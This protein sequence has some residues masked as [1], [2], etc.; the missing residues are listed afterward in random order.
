MDKE[1]NREP[2]QALRRLI[3]RTRLAVKK[4]WAEKGRDIPLG[5]QWEDPDVLPKAKAKAKARAKK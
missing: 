3:L 2:D 5:V 4:Y 1:F